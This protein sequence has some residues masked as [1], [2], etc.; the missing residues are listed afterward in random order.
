MHLNATTCIWW[1]RGCLTKQELRSQLQTSVALRPNAAFDVLP[2]SEDD[3]G[4]VDDMQHRKPS[5]TKSK[6]QYCSFDPEAIRSCRLDFIGY[7]Q[8]RQEHTSCLPKH[9]GS[10]NL[11]R[12]RQVPTQ[13]PSHPL[14]RPHLLC[15]KRVKGRPQ[16]ICS[17][18]QVGVNADCIREG[19]GW[20]TT[21]QTK[22]ISRRR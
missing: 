17:S 21:I 11:P 3:W 1:F 15:Q 13:R 9:L 14:S 12:S 16:T 2:F 19:R 6:R 5:P 18:A 10:V 22:G 8:T 20:R 7:L 4:E